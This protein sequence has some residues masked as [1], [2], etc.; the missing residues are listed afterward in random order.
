M[1]WRKGWMYLVRQMLRPLC[2]LLIST[3]L[4]ASSVPPIQAQ[5]CHSRRT[6]LVLSGGGAKGL[7]HIGALRALD[8]LGL[9]PDLIV[10]TSMGAILGALY[11]SGYSGRELDSRARELPLRDLFRAY[12]PQ[13]PR[14]L[15]ILRPLVVWEQGKRRFN[16]QSASVREAEVNALVNA[17]MLKGNL[18]ARGSFDSLLV[19]FRAVA[20][21]LSHRE[22]VVLSSGDLAQAVRA[23]AAIPLVFAPEWV[24]GRFLIDGGL[25]ANVPI[26]I[27]RNEG[28]QVVI[29]S[30]ATEHLTDSIDVDDPLIIADRL[31]GFLFDQRADSLRDRDILIRP[32]IDGFRSLDFGK[33]SV[34]AILDRGHRAADTS[35][36]RFRC[37]SGSSGHHATA[38]RDTTLPRRVTGVTISDANSSERLALERLLGLGLSDTL[39]TDLLRNRLRYLGLASEAYRSVWLRPAGGG[40]SVSFDLAL[41]RASRRV[42]V[43]G[44]A[45]D[46]ELGGRMWA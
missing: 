16:L 26:R 5:E 22:I 19:P 6:A 31:V 28:A 41:R 15:G 21:D 10:G 37:S 12:E 1:G 20:T 24:D 39:D 46:N 30:D 8:S 35:L 13:A 33:R 32:G 25:S 11:A 45:Y 23:S 17:A 29:V 14:S 4:A 44:L 18:I 7:A 9:R 36:A 43:L 42:A 27:A 2:F 3:S 40:D 34:A 38:A